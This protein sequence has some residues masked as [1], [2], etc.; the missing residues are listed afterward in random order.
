MENQWNGESFTEYSVIVCLYLTKIYGIFYKKKHNHNCEGNQW[1][2][3]WGKFK[4]FL[5]WSWTRIKSL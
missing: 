4:S 3:N 5:V 2:G 1:M